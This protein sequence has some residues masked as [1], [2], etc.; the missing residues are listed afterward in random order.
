MNS[1]VGDDLHR[2]AFDGRGPAQKLVH[3]VIPVQEVA[4][5]LV[6]ARNHHKD[7]EHLAQRGE[8]GCRLGAVS[9]VCTGILLQ[10][11]ICKHLGKGQSR[12]ITA[13]SESVSTVTLVALVPQCQVLFEA[14]STVGQ[15]SVQRRCLLGMGCISTLTCV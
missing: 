1:R 2:A 8:L 7:V 11:D 12:S 6:L 3:E 14:A 5:V 15:P 4:R 10:C 13:M 9:D